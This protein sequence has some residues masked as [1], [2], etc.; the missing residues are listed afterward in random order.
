MVKKGYFSVKKVSK[1]YSRKTGSEIISKFWPKPWKN[2]QEKTIFYVFPKSTFLWLVMAIF[3]RSIWP[4]KGKKRK[5]KSFDQNRGLPP[6]EKGQFWDFPKWIPLWSKKAIFCQESHQTL[7]L[8][9]ICL[10]RDSEK[11]V[12]IFIKTME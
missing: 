10:K 5:S 2:L 11:K 8:A 1:H 6:K 3:L 4:K 7:F 9:L 12:K